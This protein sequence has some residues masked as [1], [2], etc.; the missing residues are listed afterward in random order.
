MVFSV[1]AGGKEAFRSP[2]MLRGQPAVP[3][4][5]ELGGAREFVLVAGDADFVG[6]L[7][8][9]KDN[10]K[11]VEA[12]L[13]GEERTSV[14]LRKVADVVEQTRQ[15]FLGTFPSAETIGVFTPDATFQFM[16]CLAN[17]DAIP[18]QF[19][20]RH[21]LPANSERTH[22]PGHEQPPLHPF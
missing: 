13:F 2:V 10:G 7:Q 11:H 17:R 15:V 22:C 6:A 3:V 8:A 18:A 16:H 1:V 5:V 9:V 19:P 20:F 4:R 12:A 21:S 14:P